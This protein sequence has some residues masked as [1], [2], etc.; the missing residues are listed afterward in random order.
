M[1]YAIVELE[2]EKWKNYEAYFSD[3][4]DNCFHIDIS[5]EV[6]S[7]HVLMRKVPLKERKIIKYPQRLFG[8]DNPT[9]RAWG[10]IDDNQL[11]AGIETSIENGKNPRLYV[12]LLWVDEEYRRQGIAAALV[13]KAKERAREEKL[14]AV[15]LQTWSCNEHAIA[16]YLSQ[17]FKL[18]GFDSSPFS[19]E[20]IEKFNVPLKL[21]YYFQKGN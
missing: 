2:K 12:S 6:D 10:V 21:G 4:A 13:N 7:F 19:N 5:N 1:E 14:R 18:I 16:F 11:V 9:V 17:G 15:Y 3:F 20:D 8:S